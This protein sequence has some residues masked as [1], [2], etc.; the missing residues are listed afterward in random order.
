MPM[1]N[2]SIITEEGGA[3]VQGQTCPKLNQVESPSDGAAAG[4]VRRRVIS[5]GTAGDGK[6]V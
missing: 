1:R 2:L 5:G 4:L 6:D 3:G